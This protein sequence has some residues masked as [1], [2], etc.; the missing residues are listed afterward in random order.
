M[1]N[2]VYNTPDLN[3][4]AIVET[5]TLLYLVMSCWLVNVG[6][7]LRCNSSSSR[8]APSCAI[9]YYSAWQ[10]RVATCH[11]TS[12]MYRACRGYYVC[13]EHCRRDVPGGFL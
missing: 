9:S 3:Q 13:L 5:K 6:F 7:A 1:Y 10:Y 12:D 11:V 4:L 2:S 8:S